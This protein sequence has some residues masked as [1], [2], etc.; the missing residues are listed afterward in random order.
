MSNEVRK[1]EWLKLLLVPPMMLIACVIA[2][3]YG[4]IHNQISYTV[5]PEYF[6]TL[7]FEQFDIDPSIPDRLGA[8]LVGVYASWWMGLVLGAILVPLGL[9]IPGAKNY[10]VGMLKALGVVGLTSFVCAIV[11]LLWTLSLGRSTTQ[12]DNGLHPD[13]HITHAF[14]SVASMHVASYFGGFIGLLI[15][16]G[17]ILFLR[18]RILKNRDIVPSA[19][20]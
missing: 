4:A 17:Y 10:V 18:D 2:A 3:L 1:G 8:S 13:S 7:K 9:L 11:T 6:T 20:E 16:A 15:G 5:S 12:T 19:S 14:E